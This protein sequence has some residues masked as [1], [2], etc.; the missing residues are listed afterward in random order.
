VTSRIAVA[1]PGI[2]IAIAVV[3]VGGIAFA[4]VCA[5]VAAIALYELYNLTAA[6]RPLRWAGYVGAIAIIL[7]TDRKSVV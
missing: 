7:L 4:L 2:A 3:L 5:V 1:V 6:F